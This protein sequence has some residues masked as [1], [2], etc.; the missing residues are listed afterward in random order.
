MPKSE[1]I[2]SLPVFIAIGPL[3]RVTRKR[4]FGGEYMRAGDFLAILGAVYESCAL[5]GRMFKDNVASLAQLLQVKPGNEGEFLAFVKEKAAERL[6]RYRLIYGSDPDSVGFLLLATDYAKVGLVFPH[7]NIGST[8][9]LKRL[10]RAAQEKVDMK[11]KNVWRRLEITSGEGIGF[12]LLYPELTWDLVSR[13][14]RPVD[15]EDGDW[16]DFFRS[17]GSAVPEGLATDSPQQ[18]E[19]LVLDLVRMYVQQFRPDLAA[20]LDLLNQGGLPEGL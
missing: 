1:P 2:L 17:T 10:G 19:T 13:Q 9:D 14:H 6:G 11:N 20:T 5:L 7:G 12:G 4:L 3:Q 15:L 16:K 18:A 8:D